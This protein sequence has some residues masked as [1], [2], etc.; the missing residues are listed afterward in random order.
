[1]TKNLLPKILIAFICLLLTCCKKEH[2]RL[3]YQISV[4]K[5][6]S[7]DH[8]THEGY[9]P[10]KQGYSFMVLESILIDS[11]NFYYDYHYPGDDFIY[12]KKLLNTANGF[13]SKQRKR[14]VYF[15]K[16]S[17]EDITLLNQIL[18]TIS[19][20]QLEAR[21]CKD[22]LYHG[23]Y[24]TLIKTSGSVETFYHFHYPPKAIEE[25]F[26]YGNT[27]KSEKKN[28]LIDKSKIEEVDLKVFKDCLK[29][30]V[31]I[32]EENITSQSQS[33]K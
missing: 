3:K 21:I 20:N 25:L 11:S 13:D 29:N 9:P 18:D 7:G 6:L 5:Y 15:K 22:C 30:T 16:I 28:F 4:T 19:W 24:Y 10:E 14:L 1:M 31:P 12:S 26:K 32:Q 33:N 17:D 27:I 2:P 8:G 23:P